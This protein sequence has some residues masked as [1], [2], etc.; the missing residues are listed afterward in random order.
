ML[1]RHPGFLLR[2]PVLERGEPDQTVHAIA[3]VVRY[4]ENL[5]NAAMVSRS[6][7]QVGRGPGPMSHRWAMMHRQRGSCLRHLRLPAS[8]T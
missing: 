6:F 3:T 1:I 2:R 7:R 8:F 4:A 5:G